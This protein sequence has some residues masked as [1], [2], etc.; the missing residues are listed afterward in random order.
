VRP[1]LALIA[2]CV[3]ALAAAALPACKQDVGC[4]AGDDGTCRPPTACQALEYVCADRA[5]SMKRLS[6]PSERPSGQDAAAAAGDIVLQNSAITVVIDDLESPHHIAPTGGNI[7]DIAPRGGPDNI[8]QIYLGLG[9]LP[10]DAVAY[11]E[12]E[13]I[14][15]S[16]D[17]VAVIA[18]G[19]LDG[20][21]DTEVVTRYELRPCE[22]GLRVRSDVSYHGREPR[23]YFL[24]DAWFWGDREM[25]PLMPIRGYGF[26]DPGLSLLEIE[27]SFRRFPYMAAQAHTG[28]GDDSALASV[29]CDR[30]ELDGFNTSTIS[31]LGLPSTILL[32]DDAL[33]FE[34]FLIAA[35]GPGVSKA[36]DRALQARDQMF[37]E[38]HVSIRGNAIHPDGTPVGSDERE[39][40]LLVYEP[41]DEDDPD[42]PATRTPLTQIVPEA[43]GSFRAFVPA[44]RTLRIQPN[45]LGRPDGDV[46]VLS[47]EDGPV[48]VG[49]VVVPRGASVFVRLRGLDDW[50]VAG[51]AVLTPVDF[52][53]REPLLGGIH[54]AFEDED[55]VPYLGPIHGGSPSCNRVQLG[56]NGQKTFHVPPGAYW[57]YG[58]AGP[59]HTLDRAMI[60]VGPGDQAIVD[61]VVE[62]L[63]LLPDG[64]LSADF[65]VHAGASYDSSLPEVDR[66]RSFLA[67]DVQVIAATDHDVVSDYVDAIAT[68]GVGDRV[69]VMPGIETTGLILFFQPPGAEFPR[70][71]GH[72]NFWPLERDVL[73]S[74]NGAPQDDLL[75]PGELFDE[76]APLIQGDGVIQCNHP[77]SK[78]KFGRDEGFL[79]TVE[80][81]PRDPIPDSPDDTPGGYLIQTPGGD[82]SNIEYDVQEVING[83]SMRD[84]LRYRAGW[85]SFLSQGFLRGGTANSDS[86]TAS[87]EVLGYPRNLVF[88]GH[89]LEDFDVDAFNRSVK[90]GEIVGTNGPV[91]LASIEG[92][93]PS[94][95]ELSPAN[96]ATLSIEVRAAPWIP[97]EEV[98]IV[99]N[100]DVVRTIEGSA[101]VHPADP[102][103]N[104]DTGRLMVDVPLAELLA[105][106]DGDAW[107]V[108]EAGLPLVE[109]KDLDDDGQVDTTDNDGDGDIDK[110][111]RKGE[112]EEEPFSDPPHP[113]DDDDPRFHVDVIAPGTWPTAFTNPFL[114]D[115]DGD[116]W[117]APGL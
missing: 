49:D 95:D 43:D 62:P 35:P 16:P 34:R 3:A 99:V 90:H 55:C 70:T 63:D 22:P 102:F 18:R 26:T 65:H 93:G 112:F 114:I 115:R 109:S 30:L 60:D 86:H 8:N 111:D 46:V 36:V 32:P 17:F 21:P 52:D 20:R 108:V 88:G 13:L 39:V 97:V 91:I 82:H 40:S 74:R 61:L 75:L 15:E 27:D 14:D 76:M 73:Q 67:S 42:D 92:A 104:V 79:N 64:V 2:L 69:R 107:I 5:L 81:D 100:G 24:G 29:P 56:T 10:D 33:S 6:D 59:F 54:G 41:G 23:T 87:V 78:L 68:L 105:D 44:N 51:E 50:P 117:E 80:Y 48:D 28:E 57:V 38:P 94:L 4:M 58:T 9:I 31:A 103:G 106:V 84:Y 83:Y 7:L 98:R 113:R 66:V 89:S 72:Y 96:D 77:Y 19:R 101:L 53:E 12:L 110:D 71:I 45:V 85:F 25:T 1:V 47:T 116:G 37:A 11:H